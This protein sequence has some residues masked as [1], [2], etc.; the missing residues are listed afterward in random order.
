MEEAIASAEDTF[1]KPV[2][3]SPAPLP[4]RFRSVMFLPLKGVDRIDSFTSDWFVIDLQ[5]SVPLPSKD[6]VRNAWIE[7][8]QRPAL[9]RQKLVVRV[10]E[11]SETEHLDKDLDA[12][13]HPAINALLLPMLETAE[14]VKLFDALVTRVEMLRRL[15]PGSIRFVCLLETPAAI[16][17][18]G[19][20]AA[21]SARNIALSFGHADLLNCT[22]GEKGWDTLLFPR[23]MLVMAA[24]AAHLEVIESPFFELNDVLAFEQRGARS[25]Q[26]GF[27]GIFVLHPRQLQTANRVFSEQRSKVE[28]AR[29]I[30]NSN[31]DGCFV[32]KGTMLGPP[33]VKRLRKISERGYFEFDIEHP[34]GH[35]T[36]RLID[37]TQPLAEILRSG[38]F[39]S[40]YEIT[41]TGSWL[42][43]WQSLCFSGNPLE[44]NSKQ[45]LE[46]G[47]AG[48]PIPYNLL[49]SYALCVAVEVLTEKCFLH[50]CI[51][52]ARYHQL[53]YPGETLS[54]RIS[55]IQAQA[56]RKGAAS[57]V[58]TLHELLDSHGHLVFSVTKKT[59]YN[60][61][62]PTAPEAI[63]TPLRHIE[64]LGKRAMQSV[65][66]R[67][68][69]L[70]S[71]GPV[72]AAQPK[73]GDLLL[74]SDSRLLCR[75]ENT[76]FN[77]LFRNT[78]PVHGNYARHQEEQI[79]SCGLL[80]LPIVLGIAARDL[81]PIV[82][83]QIEYCFHTNKVHPNTPLSAV[84]YVQGIEPYNDHYDC[85]HLRTLG[86]KQVDVSTELASTRFPLA[87]F[88][89]S[90]R[91]PAEAEEL[92]QSYLPHL[93]GKVVLICDWTLYR[94]RQPRS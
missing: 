44:Y 56:A 80:T 46:H 17:N 3:I 55:V 20:I 38:S 53:V 35:V 26:L 59:L 94:P 36:G 5:D 39:S 61:M 79:V 87:L 81:K 54:A 32:D 57:I 21:A 7:Q 90:L 13:I 23:S 22:M 76:Q 68:T 37:N 83:H 65:L 64:H 10:N 9:A 15:P 41:L 72:A 6:S 30:L 69:R 2:G 82:D 86:L 67:P 45:A 75:T 34:E 71:Q 62:L 24:R 47:L 4:E 11:L 43:F 49:L 1:S 29:R 31:I 70:A 58:T 84:S 12:F 60:E 28:D 89:I 88:D 77:S 19:A 40:P 16:I 48:T 63:A 27:T 51:E 66:S 74:H 25:K 42:T 50:L 8:L 33:F 92:C 91:T 93:S 85:L 18:A 52:R 78:L 14:D 73:A